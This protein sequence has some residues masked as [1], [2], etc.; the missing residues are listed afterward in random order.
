MK[1]IRCGHRAVELF[2]DPLADQVAYLTTHTR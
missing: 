2:V 1:C